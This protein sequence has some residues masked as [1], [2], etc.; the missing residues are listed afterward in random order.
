MGR[1]V[2]EKACCICG[3]LGDEEDENCNKGPG[4]CLIGRSRHVEFEE[5]KGEDEGRWT[6]VFEV[7]ATPKVVRGLDPRGNAYTK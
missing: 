1:C 6:H 7:F 5:T 4:T 2:S 3:L